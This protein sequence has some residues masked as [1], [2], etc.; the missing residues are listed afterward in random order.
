MELL[1]VLPT[2]FL[3]SRLETAE[4]E[5]LRKLVKVTEV[6]KGEIIFHH[7]DK[8]ADFHFLI[9]GQLRSVRYSEDGKETVMHMIYEGEAFAVTSAYLD[10]PYTG[11][12]IAVKT[13][14][15]GK[16]DRKE[17]LELLRNFPEISLKMMG[18]MAQRTGQLLTRID[19]Q[20]SYTPMERVIRFLIKESKI[21][22]SSTFNL[23]L[24]KGDLARL[25]GTIP[26]T[27][28]R[29]LAELSQ[30]KAIKV[31]G[32]KISIIDELIFKEIIFSINH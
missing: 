5:A 16:I 18:M 13:S 32:K 14:L 21:K 24:T 30:K 3:F 23:S 9:K 25:L 4:I 22:N 31:D 10:I 2:V 26:E 1:T 12:S 11:T 8:P 29:C 6:S 28:S 17:F 7:G 27:L 20:T 15:V 19:E